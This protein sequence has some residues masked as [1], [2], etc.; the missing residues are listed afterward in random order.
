[1]EKENKTMEMQSKVK[2]A[3]EKVINQIIEEGLQRENIELL[4]DVIDIHKDISNE[5]YWK[6][7]EEMYMYNRGYNEGGYGRRGRYNE[8]PEYGARGRSRDSRGRYN[9]RGRYGHESEDMLEEMQEHF[10]NYNEA[11]EECNR[12]N[13]NASSDKMMSLEAML[14]SGTD[15][16]EMLEQEAESPEEI[17]LVKKYARKI[18]NM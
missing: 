11:R 10:G 6:I 12:G 5:E 15:F 17:E 7:K 1:M 13:Y 3:T 8:M 9:G 18:G 4:G 2:E 14:Q 16:F